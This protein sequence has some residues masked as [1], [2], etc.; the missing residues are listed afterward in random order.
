MWLVDRKSTTRQAQVT[1][2]TKPS[3]KQP[4]TEDGAKHVG[5]MHEQTTPGTGND[6]RY[7]MESSQVASALHP[8][9]RGIG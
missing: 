4:V 2:P 9:G 8:S 6:Q 5:W 7:S 1:H 3:E